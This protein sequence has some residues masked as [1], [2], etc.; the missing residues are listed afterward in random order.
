MDRTRAKPGAVLVISGE[1]MANYRT[2]VNYLERTCLSTE[3]L[4]FDEVYRIC[5]ARVDSE[6]IDNK[7]YFEF[8]GFTVVKI[9][10]RDKTVTF[11]RKA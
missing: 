6:F 1:K 7:R 10:L 8:E 9:N 2:L 3:K 5:G 4:T 11:A